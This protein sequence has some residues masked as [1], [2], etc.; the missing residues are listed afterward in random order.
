M[1]HCY[2]P[3]SLHHPQRRSQCGLKNYT[4]VT[5]FADHR[6]HICLPSAHASYAGYR[7]KIKA[8]TKPYTFLGNV[9]HPATARYT[10]FQG[11]FDDALI[12][13]EIKASPCMADFEGVWSEIIHRNPSG[14]V[15]GS[16]AAN[17]DVIAE[18][19]R[20]SINGGTTA[21]ATVA[22]HKQA[23]QGFFEDNGDYMI[24]DGVPIAVHYISSLGQANYHQ[25]VPLY[26]V[27]SDS[28]DTFLRRRTARYFVQNGSYPSAFDRFETQ[29]ESGGKIM[30]YFGPQADASAG[31]RAITPGT[32]YFSMPTGPHVATLT[33]K[34][35][36]GSGASLLRDSADAAA[37]TLDVDSLS[38]FTA[39]ACAL[40]VTLPIYA[41]I[42]YGSGLQNLVVNGTLLTSSTDPPSTVLSA[43]D[44]SNG[45][46]DYAICPVVF[47]GPSS[48]DLIDPS[49]AV[50]SWTFRNTVTNI[51][52][53]P[54]TRAKEVAATFA[55]PNSIY[56]FVGM[57]VKVPAVFL[58]DSSYYYRIT[59]QTDNDD[60]ALSAADKARVHASRFGIEVSCLGRAPW[61][62]GQPT[63]SAVAA[64][65]QTWLAAN[66]IANAKYNGFSS[67]VDWWTTGGGDQTGLG[68]NWAFNAPVAR[69]LDTSHNINGSHVKDAIGHVDTNNA[70]LFI[71]SLRAR[72]RRMNVRVP[73]SRL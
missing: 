37:S 40:G 2:S 68:N 58:W 31:R 56:S 25:A 71:T 22:H 20:Q 4:N 72:L 38:H 61:V 32:H 8:L 16:W 12:T 44:F 19:S 35:T 52:Y 41:E 15:G 28:N 21:G 70:I 33:T 18:F 27:A 13:S 17:A 54:A 43:A 59:Y 34:M 3:S 50:G 65:H 6:C 7:E 47:T 51:W 26:G 10:G 23:Q 24:A 30:S 14:G 45:L 46:W 48:P 5:I 64:D 36:F 57:S 66:T 69:W 29:I 67:G 9:V 39:L 73:G 49:D 55:S 1:P 63:G 62:S 11:Q 60:T 42:S 53:D